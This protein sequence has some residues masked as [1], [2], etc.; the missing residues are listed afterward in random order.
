MVFH[1]PARQ[2]GAI[3]LMAALTLGLALLFMLLVVDS[4][5][6]YMEQRKLQRIADM[7]ALEAAGQHAVCTGTGPQATALARSAATRNGH[8]PSDPL[9][10]SCGHV[11]TGADHLRTF[12]VDASRN[13]AI[14]VQ[15]SHTVPTS[16]AAGVLALVKGDGLPLTST[17][18]ASAVASVPTQPQ[19]MLRIR[20]TLV[21][22]DSRKAAL[23]N[24]LLATLGGNVQLDVAGWQGLA[25]TQLNLLK[26]LDQLAVDLNI[27]A[28]DY[29]TLLGTD[30]SA[31][32]LLQAAVKVLQQSGAAVDVVT[33]LGRVASAGGGRV[34]HLD[35]LLDI[36]SGTA[37]AGL[38][39]SL[40]LL[41]LVHGMLLLAA[42]DS[43]VGIDLSPSLLGL[44]N[45]RVRVKVL[46]PPQ[47]SSIGD[48]SKDELRV[49]TAQVKVLVSVDLPVLDTI[50]GLV[51]AVLDL[52]AP[53]TN[54]LNNLLSLN[55]LGTVQS[56]T[57][58]LGIPCKVSDI[59]LMPNKVHLDIGLEVS[60]ATSRLKPPLQSSYSCA[61]KR[62]TTLTDRSAVKISVGTFDSP[63]AFF[64]QGTSANKALPLIDIGTNVCSRVLI[65][66]P[67][68]GTRV[69]FAGGGIGVRVDSKVLGYGQGEHDLVFQGTSEPPEIGQNPRYLP[70]AIANSNVVSSLSDT[71]LGIHLEAYEPTANSG[72]GK[73]MV[74]TAGL[75]DGVKSILEPLIKN[76]LSPIID[77]LVDML[78]NMLGI[79]LVNAEVGANLSCASGRA[80]LV[81]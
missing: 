15:V 63:D 81:Q 2:R 25:D 40:Q 79:D 61:P 76:L 62:L 29:Q 57:C 8:D 38:D 9:A 23:L 47:I 56:L 77:P 52:A 12:S 17:L 46:E 13:E 49:H 67:V 14:R 18:T 70:M 53:L 32:Q 3:G 58:S 75:L 4:G 34:L 42:G 1:S 16:V 22:L 7:A 55:L 6:L 54:V 48:P 33:N 68:C 80:Q 72:L 36:Q 51:N 44:V 66:P 74:L 11:Q 50:F 5:R 39:A 19:A 73:I 35:E 31:T 24:A 65:L 43:A 41:Q 26:Y 28:G 78:L 59:K 64:A 60:E 71:L 21:T 37:K 20:S 45:G 10:A 30:A 27:K 69:P